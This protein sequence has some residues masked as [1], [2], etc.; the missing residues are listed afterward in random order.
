M[1]ILG[2]AAAQELFRVRHFGLV[3]AGATAAA[4]VYTAAVTGLPL[5]T[6][7]IVDRALVARD[8]YALVQR[9]LLLVALAA[10]S[11]LA[12]G[13]QQTAFAWLRERSRAALQARLLARLL[14]LPI[15]FF[16]RERAG[17]LQSLLTEDAA[18]AARQAYEL[19]AESLL[20]GLQLAFALAVVAVRYGRIAWVALLLIPLYML[21]PLLFARRTRGAAHAALGATAEVASA[22]HESVQGVREVRLF[23]REGWAL[24]RLGRLLA[25]EVAQQV[26]LQRLRSA[27]ALDYIVYFAVVSA[28]YWRGGLAVLG[29]RLTLG[30]LIALVVLLGMLANPVGRLT[31]VGAEAQR[32]A[33]AL[34]RLEELAGAAAEPAP[35]GGR[36]LGPGAHR[37]CFAGV[38]FRYPG[39]AAPALRDITLAVEPGTVVAVVGPSGAGKSTLAGLLAR[40]YEPQAGRILIDG[41]DLRDY[42]LASLRRELGCVLQ[43]PVLFAGSVEENI[44]FG[45]LDAT[46]DE[47]EQSARAAG[48][49][50]FIARLAAGY[51]SEV[52]ERGVQLSG[53]QRQRLGIAR[54]LLRQ[55]SILIL[56]EATSALDA[57]TER[58][59]RQSLRRR[60]AGRTMLV[61]SH[62]PSAFVDA[63]RILVLDRGRIA[64]AGTHA[65]LLAASPVYRRLI[66]TAEEPDDGDGRDDGSPQSSPAGGADAAVVTVAARRSGTA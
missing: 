56:D 41:Q 7:S 19:L 10:L 29:G 33:A 35:A 64:A 1:T 61:I 46:A 2:R 24:A 4:A 40:L 52:G 47:V 51:A 62:R 15:A 50:A 57:E 11:T 5:V 36:E 48:A 43:D 17:R 21:P 25:V 38:D 3:L 34:D 45:K 42:S 23:A 55:P 54:V 26:R 60:L 53:G 39:T 13:V 30:E 32:L 31:R 18:S 63:D 27:L 6:G 12:N 20:G 59:V 8:P 58:Q 65:E 28:V 22:L 44:R 37:I 49:D 16:D 9:T 14:A 66:A